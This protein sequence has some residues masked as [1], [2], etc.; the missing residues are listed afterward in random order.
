MLN[1][2]CMFTSWCVGCHVVVVLPC[3]FCVCFCFL[4]FLKP[5]SCT[6]QT[7]RKWELVVF[8]SASCQA[9]N[10]RMPDYPE[11]TWGCESTGY[12]LLNK[13][14]IL[15]KLRKWDDKFNFRDIWALLLHGCRVKVPTSLSTFLSQVWLQVCA[16]CF[17]S[18]LFLP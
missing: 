13:T 5:P 17:F 6:H 9:E 16:G 12:R 3:Y 8:I 10:K 1:L 18:L 11:G 14:R 2:C 7:C 4:L 15:S